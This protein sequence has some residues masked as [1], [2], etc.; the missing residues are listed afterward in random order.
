M[1]APEDQM[2]V[3]QEDLQAEGPAVVEPREQRS[4]T[5]IQ[6]TK[7]DANSPTAITPIQA[8]SEPNENADGGMT[9]AKTERQGEDERQG[10]EDEQ[11][12]QDQSNQDPELV[13]EEMVSGFQEGKKRVKVSFILQMAC[14]VTHACT[15]S[16]PDFPP[17][18][19]ELHGQAW[20]D[21]GTGFVEGI[22]DEASDEA[23]LVVTREESRDG[24]N[25]AA[26]QEGE[27]GG[28]AE[29]E[30]GP[31]EPGGFLREGEDPFLLRSKVGKTE[32]YSRQQGEWWYFVF[33]AIWSG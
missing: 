25:G 13:Q 1:S 6:E 22:Y 7:H 31:L 18:V 32:Q 9:A 23:L 30:E 11:D 8:S 17:K 28:L 27:Q 29:N 19:Y 33:L 21:K 10:Q 2:K 4:E 14:R 16:D 5:H 12:E 20:E 3:V 26:Q 24:E 15:S